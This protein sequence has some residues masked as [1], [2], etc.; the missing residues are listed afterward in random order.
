MS[1]EASFELQE[2]IE[3]IAMDI[4]KRAIEFA[5]DD[6]RWKVTREDVKKGFEE[7]LRSF[8]WNEY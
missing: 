5:Y 2:I 6:S 3:K 4:S 7:L 1:D 8:R